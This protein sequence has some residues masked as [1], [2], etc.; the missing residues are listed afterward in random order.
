VLEERVR[1]ELQ[2][3]RGGAERVRMSLAQDLD[4]AADGLLEM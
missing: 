3:D 1:D 4:L 2:A